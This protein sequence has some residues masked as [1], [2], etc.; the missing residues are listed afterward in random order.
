MNYKI[1]G[2]INSLETMVFLHGWGCDGDIWTDFADY[3][4]VRYKIVLFDLHSIEGQR[5]LT[6]DDYA[7][8][9]FD[10]LAKENVH[11][12]IFVVHSFGCRVVT[13]MLSKNKIAKKLIIFGGA[14]I[15]PK[16]SLKRWLKIKI[17]KIKKKLKL[18]TKKCGSK[19]W[20]KLDRINK[21][22]F[23]NII[24]TRQEADFKAINTPTMII[25]GGR[26]KDTPKYM[27]KKMHELIAD[28]KLHIIKNASHFCFLDKA[29]ECKL[30]VDFFVDV[31]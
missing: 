16:F 28:S 5:V 27:A 6:I 8:A 31:I 13:R 20:Q 29:Q 18:N 24:K 30:L 7:D 17:Y 11:E 23:V 9:V 10:E 14:G 4:G 2:N 26:D 22:T 12:A 1:A 3:F 19:D 15:K 25:V 21:K